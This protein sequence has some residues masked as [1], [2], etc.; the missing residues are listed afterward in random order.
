MTETFMSRLREAIMPLHDE[1]EKFGPLHAIPAKSLTVDA[2]A[3]ILTRLYGFVLPAEKTIEDMI[4]PVKIFPDYMN[5][6]RVPHLEKDISFLGISERD[7][8]EPRL[9]ETIPRIDNIPKAIGCLYLFEGSR[10][11]GLVLAKAL[12]EQF[13]FDN[14]KGYAYFGSNGLDVP[15]LW[16]SFRNTVEDYVSK[17]GNSAEIIAAATSGFAALNRWLMGTPVR[18]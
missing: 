14:N 17:E 3:K 7:L 16:K 8:R 15:E 10:L 1:A 13:G 12:R 6:R 9:C 5:R 2:Y 11:G 18:Q 4:E